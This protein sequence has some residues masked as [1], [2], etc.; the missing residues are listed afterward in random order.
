MNLK[1]LSDRALNGLDAIGYQ[2]DN[3]GITN[4]INRHSLIALIMAEQK[5][6]EGEW[7]SLQAR[8]GSQIRQVEGLVGRVRGLIRA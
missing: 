6:L 3:V 8:Y 7:D 4:K 2:L 5:H 1:S